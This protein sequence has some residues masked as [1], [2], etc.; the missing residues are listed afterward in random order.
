M[1]KTLFL[2]AVLLLGMTTAT[3]QEETGKLGL[4]VGLGTT[5][6]SI[7]AAYKP[8]GI[9]G[10]RAGVD[11]DPRVSYKHNVEVRNAAGY[12]ELVDAGMGSLGL[13]S[14]QVPTEVELEG[15]T[16]ISSGHVLVDLYP[17]RKSVFHFT[18]GA[19]LGSDNV[20]NVTTVND[21]YL[22]G[23]YVYNRFCE[24]N[25]TL[26]PGYNLNDYK[27]GV[28]LGDYFLEPDADGHVKADVRVKKFRPYVGIGV[29]R[30]VP[31]RRIGVSFDFGVQ[32]WG[33]PELWAQDH[34]L[35]KD[36]FKGK[37]GGM[38]EVLTKISVWPMLTLRLTGRIL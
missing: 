37:D 12:Q 25:A 27:V 13:P 28:Q 3:A 20:V 17:G 1:K 6:I 26:I 31:N 16:K 30:C 36:D 10:V 33:K 32:I 9:I 24:Q 29:G 11:I 21:D 8:C 4:N 14:V 7:D 19:Y 23:V 2:T 35:S 22:K 38:V 18:V 15:R 5:G 34:Q